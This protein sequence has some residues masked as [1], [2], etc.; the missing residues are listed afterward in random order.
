MCVLRKQLFQ[1]RSNTPRE[2]TVDAYR[3]EEEQIEALKKWWH[4]NGK[5]I[6]AGIVIGIV[7]IFGWRSWKEHQIARAESASVLYEQMIIASRNN[8]LDNAKV[9]ANRVINEFTNSSY[10]IYARLML[11]R[12]AAEENDLNAA[13]AELRTVLKNSQL[14]ELRHIAK[15]RLA[16][17]LITAEKL[18]DARQLLNS[19]SDQ[20]TAHYEELRGDIFVLEGNV[21]AAREAYQKALLS[22]LAV[23]DNQSILEIKMDDLG[24]G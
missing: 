12:L 11:T 10:A 14:P 7:A 9:F 16:R 22:N 4:E 2:I 24:R 18:D 21:D 3:T 17:I 19:D 1:T 23:G 8:D 6:V 15:L 20:F 5:S 13:E